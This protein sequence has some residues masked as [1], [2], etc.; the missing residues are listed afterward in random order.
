MKF[1]ID[2]QV[3]SILG[4]RDIKIVDVT[5]FFECIKVKIHPMTIQIVDA[6]RVAGSR[7]L[8]FAY[9]N[10]KKAHEQGRRISDNLE[11]EILLYASGQRQIVK[12]I[13]MI[14][15]KPHTSTLAI[16]LSGSSETEVNEAEG[17]LATSIGG[18][19]DDSVLDV[20]GKEK[21]KDLQQIYTITQLEIETMLEN[22]KQIHEVLTWL[23]VER[24]SLLSLNR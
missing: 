4:F 23:I 3:I 8:F 19:R 7:H 6:S 11:M 2:D 9:L 18:I 20:Q 16:L 5:A 15:V 17:L 21:I 13:D 12:A 10:A 1:N 22:S 14:G 24:V